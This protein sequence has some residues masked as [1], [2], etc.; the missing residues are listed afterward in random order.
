MSVAKSGCDRE[1]VTA[2]AFEGVFRFSGKR[3]H[4]STASSGEQQT[5]DAHAILS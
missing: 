2:V 3:P 1:V 5:N 4:P